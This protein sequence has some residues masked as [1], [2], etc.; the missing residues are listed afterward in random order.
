[1]WMGCGMLLFSFLNVEVSFIRLLIA[2]EVGKLGGA[3][4]RLEVVVMGF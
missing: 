3:L 2:S 4:F 1:M